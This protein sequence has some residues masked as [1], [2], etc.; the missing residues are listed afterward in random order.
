MSIPRYGRSTPG[1][2]HLFTHTNNLTLL[3]FDYHR[4]HLNYFLSVTLFAFFESVRIHF[5]RSD[6]AVTWLNLWSFPRSVLQSAKWSLTAK[7]GSWRN[8][9]FQSRS[10]NKLTGWP[11]RHR[12]VIHPRPSD[13][14]ACL[15]N[16]D[17]TQGSC[18]FNSHGEDSRAAIVSS[19]QKQQR[20]DL[21]RL[22]SHAVYVKQ[23]NPPVKWVYVID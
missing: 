14:W 2:R 3:G 18:F 13:I 15:L 1:A 20:W 12:T 21:V 10:R 23:L 9:V 19:K 5:F 16:D 6:C 17:N 22:C 7:R 4:D 11:S 8:I